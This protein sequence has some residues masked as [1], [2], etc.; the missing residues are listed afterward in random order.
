MVNKM[1]LETL[2]V[3]KMT[4]LAGEK[5]D[6][7]EDYVDED[8]DEGVLWKDASEKDFEEFL[9]DHSAMGKINLNGKVVGHMEFGDVKL[10]A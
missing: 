6:D 7:L 5:D 2:R 1:S 3:V 10:K 9:D 8:E 4:T